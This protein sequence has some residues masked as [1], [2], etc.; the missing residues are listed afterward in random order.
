MACLSGFPFRFSISPLASPLLTPPHFPL[1][2][3]HPQLWDWDD[4]DSDYA[5]M[6]EAPVPA[7]M[8][9]ANA[10]RPSTAAAVAATGIDTDAMILGD[11]DEY[12]M[13]RGKG[14]RPTTAGAVG[15]RLT[16]SWG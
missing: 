13:S 11:G 1:T 3:T 14:D 5:M 7:N 4:V 8:Q 9:S 12:E 2:L 10:H 6:G 15:T 16:S